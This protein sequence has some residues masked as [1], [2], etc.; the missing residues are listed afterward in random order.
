MDQIKIYCVLVINIK[1]ISKLL[2]DTTNQ[3]SMG[4]LHHI[5]DKIEEYSKQNYVPI[6]KYELLNLVGLVYD[7]FLDDGTMIGDVIN[8]SLN[9]I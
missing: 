2:Q 3:I 5:V 9:S 8:K 4:F 1:S 7:L 6:I